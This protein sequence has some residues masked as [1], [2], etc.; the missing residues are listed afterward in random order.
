MINYYIKF[1]Y[2]ISHNK[3]LNFYTVITRIYRK[4]VRNRKIDHI[5]KHT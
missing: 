3:I 1:Q 5:N 2:K 4:G